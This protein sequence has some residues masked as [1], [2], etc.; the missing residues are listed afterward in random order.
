MKPTTLPL[1]LM[2]AALLAAACGDDNGGASPAEPTEPG[3]LVVERTTLR[4]VEQPI[5]NGLNPFVCDLE[6]TARNDTTR[7]RKGALTFAAFDRDGQR[8]EW[9]P[10]GVDP[11]GGCGR[12]ITVTVLAG[13]RSD[14]LV[15]TFVFDSCDKVA[16]VEILEIRSEPVA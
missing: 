9:C 3:G 16:R 10:F 15:R 1:M 7:D 4:T 11:E 5:R 2:L 14:F 12:R 13:G 8:I 6:G